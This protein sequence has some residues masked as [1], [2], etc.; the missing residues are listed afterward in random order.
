MVDKA[1]EKTGEAVDKVQKLGSDAINHGEN[2]ANRTMDGLGGLL[3]EAEAT[4]ESVTNS[5]SVKEDGGG[6]FDRLKGKV[7][8]LI[9]H[10]NDT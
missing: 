7:T 6:L 9:G 10:K 3:G 8:D 2:A 5:E 4:A 1:Q